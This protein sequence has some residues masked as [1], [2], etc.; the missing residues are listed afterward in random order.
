M[1]RSFQTGCWK[2][3]P[4]VA[5]RDQ[6]WIV[7]YTLSVGAIDQKVFSS[8]VESKSGFSQLS[9][10]AV[11]DCNSAGRIISFN[12]GGRCQSKF[13][14]RGN[15]FPSESIDFDSYRGKR[16]EQLLSG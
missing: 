6:I 2:A 14:P 7:A 5:V 11:P 16:V 12:I 1:T 10:G 13:R 3:A 15:F 8:K 9:I 4:Y